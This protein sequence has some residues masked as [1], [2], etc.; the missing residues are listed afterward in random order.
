MTY[1][2]VAI[3]II[4][5]DLQGHAPNA[6]LLKCDSSYSCTAGYEISTDIARTVVRSLT[7]IHAVAEPLYCEQLRTDTLIAN[8]LVTRRATAKLKAQRHCCC[9]HIYFMTYFYAPICTIVSGVL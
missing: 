8:I 5:N 9:R 2:I 7:P 3:L 6:G 4:L 1:R